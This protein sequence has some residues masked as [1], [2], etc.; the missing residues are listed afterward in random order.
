MKYITLA[1]LNDYV[2]GRVEYGVWTSIHEIYAKMS[3]K[4]PPSH[5]LD[6]CGQVGF[7]LAISF[8]AL[9]LA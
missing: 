5:L 2:G 8:R 6:S 3:R 7:M 1:K 4:G 9:N